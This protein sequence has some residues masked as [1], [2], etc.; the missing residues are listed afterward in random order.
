MIIYITCVYI[1]IYIYTHIHIYLYTHIHSHLVSSHLGPSLRR[2]AAAPRRPRGDGD[3][4]HG[5]AAAGC[6]RPR[7]GRRA[8]RGAGGGGRQGCR[9]AA[10][11]GAAREK[12]SAEGAADGLVV[13]VRLRAGRHAGQGGG[14][15][16]PARQPERGARRKQSPLLFHYR[17]IVIELFW[18][19]G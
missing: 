13:L 15:L 4:G 12:V 11:R 6:R 1:Y 8:G 10:C 19:M 17:V 9:G 18:V 14:H 7:A 3:R 16:P 2:R 5:A